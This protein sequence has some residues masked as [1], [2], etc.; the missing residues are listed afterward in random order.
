VPLLQGRTMKAIVFT[1]HG[2]LDKVRPAEVARP[3]PAAG[4]VLIAVRSAALNHLDIWARKGRRG[5]TLSMPHTLGS[6]ASGVISE[7]GQDVTGF[8]KGDEVII[9]PGLSCRRCE[10]CL[11]GEHSECETFGIIGMNREG[12][13]AEYVAVPAVNVYRKPAFLN[14]D[15]AAA[16]PLVYTTAW[17][18]L[19]TRARS[20][21]CN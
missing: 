2:D 1:E 6:D 11:R 17:R 9:N 10:F 21:P 13:F 20:K 15:E 3:R 18:M 14:F 16:L 5:I 4:E 19:I 7:V 8:S 12:T